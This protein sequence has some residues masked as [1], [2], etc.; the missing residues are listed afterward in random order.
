MTLLHKQML[1]NCNECHLVIVF[2]SNLDLMVAK[3]TIQ[4][5]MDF[6]SRDL[7]QNFNIKILIYF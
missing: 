5:H 3:K 2:T 7:V 4:K 6:M 1:P